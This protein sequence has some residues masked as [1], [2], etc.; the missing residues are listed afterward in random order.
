MKNSDSIY[1][2]K[3]A[4]LP[5]NILVIICLL[6]LYGFIILYSAAGG[7]LY[8]WA[9]KQIITFSIFF[10][11][12]IIIALIDIK[13]IYKFSYIFYFLVLLA[14]VAVE[15]FGTVAL[16][17]KRWINLGFASLQPSEAAK[18]GVVL[19]LAKYLHGIAEENIS[20]LSSLVPAGLLVLVPAALIIK[21][22]DLGTGII[23]IVAAA[24]M[25]FAASVNIYYFIILGTCS[26]ISF[27]LVWIFLKEYQKKR[28]SIFLNPDMDPLASGY[29]IIQSKISVGSGGFFGKGFTNGT[30]TRLDFLPEGQTDFIFA[31]LAEEFGFFGSLL[32]IILYSYLIIACVTIVAKSKNVFS[33]LT[34]TG[35][36]SVFFTHI[37][38]NIGMVTGLL[39]VVGVPL[40]FISQ[41]G[42]MMASTLVGFGVI[43][44]CGI[45]RNKILG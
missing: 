6:C 14:L 22:P 12:S 29:N 15:L 28:I 13:I 31:S 18:I 32:L 34:V 3:I 44:N 16:G 33:R 25:F 7:S 5:L 43:M 17:G 35:I 26:I 10:P 20:K 27:P 24:F 9:Y 21:E 38:V 42:T 45:N 4:K 11:L 19:A 2:F 8:P 37:F 23:T 36:S 39:P 30:Q 41:G 40:P 1:F